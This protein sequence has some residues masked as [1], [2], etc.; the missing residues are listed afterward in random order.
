[1]RSLPFRDLSSR[2]VGRRIFPFPAAQG[3]GPDLAIKIGPPSSDNIVKSFHF[4]KVFSPMKIFQSHIN[5]W[6]KRSV[7]ILAILFFLV[8]AI[9]AGDHFVTQYYKLK[10]SRLLQYSLNGLKALVFYEL[11][12]YG[13]A[14]QAW[15]DHHG[16][17]YDPKLMEIL[18]TA[19][20]KEIEENPDKI[21]NYLRLADL[22]FSAADYANATITYRNA[23]QKNKNI[24]DA[25]VG[26]ASSLAIQG[27]HHE[28]QAVFEELFNQG[29][30]EKSVTSFLNFLVALDKVE[31]SK[32]P[33]K[34]DLYLSLA[35]AY[36]YLSIIDNRKSEEVIAYANKAIS[37]SKNLDKAFLCKGVIYTKEK[38]YELALEQFSKLLQGNALNGEA[39]SRMAYIHGELGNLESELEYYKRAV[40]TEE[41]N[42]DYAYN[43]GQ[44]LQ[45]KYGDVNQAIL[46]LKKAYEIDPDNFAYASTYAY[47]LEM[48]RQF[49][50]AL[51]VYDTII[52][53]NPENPEGYILE[54]H[55]LIRMERYEEAINLF[56]KAS[57]LSSLNF[58][59]ARDLALAYSNLKNFENA[60]SLTEYALRIRPYD[61]DTLYFLQY[62]YRRKG[63]YEEAYRAVKE[64]LSIQPNHSGAL[65]VLPYLQGNLGKRQSP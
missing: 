18:K 36:R 65:R 24:Y 1:M 38:N 50:N 11:G 12:Q 60:I 25:K 44:L 16:L 27:K 7:K 30:N 2:V 37:T 17:S 10:N 54:A 15:R 39:Y 22:Y 31:K 20:L 8:L 13:K 55:C 41:K 53:K 14:S 35:Y 19:L 3:E 40:A 63:K 4:I 5:I 26:L 43:L 58:N 48:L 46:Y 34:A 49:Y 47:T 62:L 9:I 28:S 21:D 29:Y 33:D 56:L 32:I 52:R 59:A 42:P 23:L 45:R 6:K 61:V 64:I 57:T 51:E